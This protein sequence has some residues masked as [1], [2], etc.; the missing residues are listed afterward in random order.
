MCKWFSLRPAEEVVGLPPS[1][2]AS[3]WD[4]LGDLWEVRGKKVVWPR[5]AFAPV[6]KDE[7]EPWFRTML[8]QTFIAIAHEKDPSRIVWLQARATLL[9]D[10]LEQPRLAMA[11]VEAA[12]ENARGKGNHVQVERQLRDMNPPRYVVTVPEPETRERAQV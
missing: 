11:K 9:N 7:L 4:D 5:V 8:L 6:Y 1:T 2:A 10:L 3:S 12:M